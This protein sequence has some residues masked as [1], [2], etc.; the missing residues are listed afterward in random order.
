[1]IDLEWH[2]VIA[3]SC[4]GRKSEHH[5]CVDVA[6]TD[7]TASLKV[8]EGVH[9]RA[10]GHDNGFCF[11]QLTTTLDRTA[12][13]ADI[14][15][16]K[17][18]TIPVPMGS[19][20]DNSSGL[21]ASAPLFDNLTSAYDQVYAQGTL[22]T[23]YVQKLVSRLSP[24]QS[25]LDIG[26]ATG[27]PNGVLLEKAGLKVTGIDSSEKMIKQAKQNVPSGRFIL[28][29]AK[30]FVPSETYD[31]VVCSLAL[32]SE[33][34]MWVDSLAYRISSWLKPSG[35]LLF[36]TIDFNDFPVAP[37]CPIDPTGL[38]LHHTFMETSI[39]DSTSEPGD[40][41]KTLR[42]AGLPLLECEQSTFDPRPGTIEPE[43]QY[44]FLASKTAKH[45][46]LG[47]YKHPYKHLAAPRALNATSWDFVRRRRVA[48]SER[49]SWFAPGAWKLDSPAHLLE[50]CPEGVV[51]IE[52]D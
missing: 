33:P 22:Q 16:L 5:T 38:T 10:E 21:N 41:I 34:S 44:F 6:Q 43:P 1:M 4:L 19:V 52:L 18:P 28:K 35:L 23:E 29:D 37:G 47:P 27:V 26:C 12:P 14:I 50:N 15:E 48:D 24:G 3:L 2:H 51:R 46:L 20:H 45:A 49:A 36:G 32:L 7:I 25:V 42:Q 31:A 40:W 8:Q 11:S 39:T 13:V 9:K 17:T 30:S